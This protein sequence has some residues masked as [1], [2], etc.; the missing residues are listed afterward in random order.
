MAS[1]IVFNTITGQILQSV[2]YDNPFNI[3][4]SEETLNFILD[5][6]GI[7]EKE[8]KNYKIIKINDDYI[9]GEARIVFKYENNQLVKKKLISLMLIDDFPTEKKFKCLNE[10]QEVITEPI[11]LTVDGEDYNINNGE[12]SLE[13]P[14]PTEFEVSITRDKNYFMFPTII[15][16]G[17]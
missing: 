8:R 1:Q 16:V 10:N 12:F 14:V 7:L 13:S 3:D 15:E 6:H 17:K 2:V 4:L 5:N 9:T 11:I